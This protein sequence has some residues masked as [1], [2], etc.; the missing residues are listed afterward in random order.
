MSLLSREIT[1][2]L[3]AELKSTAR[4]GEDGPGN[5]NLGHLLMKEI[6]KE[7]AKQFKEEDSQ[8]SL[9]ALSIQVNGK[10]TAEEGLVKAE[11]KLEK[12]FNKT[13][14]GSGE[15]KKEKEKGDIEKI[16]LDDL[17]GVDI[18]TIEKLEKKGFKVI[19]PNL[20]YRKPKYQNVS[21]VF[22]YVESENGKG[23]GVKLVIMNFND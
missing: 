6:A 22:K 19:Y 21:E 11:E 17:D 1:A 18:E 8:D 14:D 10:R 3:I 23:D 12:I 20:K 2:N 15:E 7:V 13:D 16:E 5:G 9:K 4:L